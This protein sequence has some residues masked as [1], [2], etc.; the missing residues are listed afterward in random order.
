MNL[1]S[2]LLKQVA[3]LR[4]PLAVTIVSGWLGGVLLVLYARVLSRVVSLVFL[5]ASTPADGPSLPAL[6]AA[7]LALA[8]LR[9]GSVW[10]GRVTAQQTANG[11]KLRLRQ[12]L[13]R[14]LLKLGPAY[15]WGERTGELTN[16]LTEGIEA[17]DAYFGLYVPQLV[18]AVLVPLTIF[19]FVL[20]LDI[21]S[22]VIL[23]ATAP[24]I[25]LFMVLIGA[26]AGQMTQRQWTSLSR[27]SAH[28]LD[29]L[30]GLTTLKLLGRSRQQV[31]SVEAASEDFR[32]MTMGVLRIAFLSAL[33]L[34]MLAT[35]STAVVAVEIGLR[36]LYGRLVFEQAFFVLLLAP[37][38]YLPLRLLGTRFH[39]GAAGAASAR[40]IFEI[41][42][43]PV[44]SSPQV[45]ADHIHP[46]R[47]IRFS[48]VYYAY[49]GGARPALHG[50][51]LDLREGQRAALVGASGAG[52][53]TVVHLL[54]R[55]IA[56]DTGSI[57]VDGRSLQQIDPE[58]WRQWVAWVPQSPYL[59]HASV[60]E[61]IRLGRPEAPLAAVM[62]AAR[63]AHAEAFI[64]ELPD[65]YETQIGERGFRLSGG[66]AQRLALARAFLKDAP[67]LILDEATSSL[68]PVH[69]ALLQQSL[70]RLEEGRTVLT[71]AHRLSTV[72]HADRIY[73]LEGGRVVESGDH[74]SLLERQGVYFTMVTGGGYLSPGGEDGLR[75]AGDGRGLSG[76]CAQ[77]E[78]SG[79][80]FL[81]YGFASSDH[82]E[83][84]APAPARSG[85]SRA[86]DFGRLLRILAPYAGW[87]LLASLVGF[88]TIGSSIGLM[89]A[90]AY[91]IASAALHPSIAE[92]QV[93]IV[94]VRFFGIS[95]GGFRYL[96]RL[97]SHQATFRLLTRLRVWFYRSLEPLAPARLLQYRSGDLL[98]RVVADIGTLENFYLRVIAPP[99]VAVMVAVLAAVFLSSYHPSL[100]LVVLMGLLAAGVLMPVL[101]LR[102]SRGIGRR[103]IE[104]RARLSALIV[105]GV[106]GVAE[107][108]AFNMVE[109]HMRLVTRLDAGLQRLHLRLATVAGLQEGLFGLLVNLTTLGALIVGIP[110]VGSGAISGVSLAVLVLVTIATF[111]A[112]APLPAAWQHLE[113]NL[114]AARRLF[115][116]LDAAPAVTDPAQPLPLPQ[117]YAPS[118]TC[119]HGSPRKHEDRLRVEDLS[120]RYTPEAPLALN[121]VSLTLAPGRRVVLVGPSGSGKTTLVNLLLR[122]W[123]YDAGHIWLGTGS[124]QGG[125]LRDYRAEDVRR[126]LGVVGQAVHLFNATVRENLLLARPDAAEDDLVR[127]TQ[128]A[129]IYDFIVSLPQGLDTWIGEQG[130]LLSAGQRQ[131]LAVA[132][133]LLR[134]TPVLIFDEPTANLDPLVAAALMRD[135]L[136]MTASR[137]SLFITHRLVGLE[138]MDEILVLQRGR[139]VERGRHDELMQARG[140]YHRMWQ[141]HRVC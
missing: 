98:T 127:V 67:L 92:L 63:L 107:Q 86:R 95:R 87:M 49:E 58:Q 93:A 66:Q 17:L 3:G 42:E 80:T 140:L 55:F 7:L 117:T 60:A 41:L 135:V 23:L 20:P 38:F 25:P 84:A 139:I 39:D 115:E 18:T 102:L 121:G 116:I 40:R 131:R 14:H 2:R 141:L 122:F 76:S 103:T 53:S 109:R 48:E 136:Q 45:R 78:E 132:R 81:T 15:S 62:E 133:V 52:K 27:M 108:L 70:A 73:V 13:S 79:A 1:D 113:T 83:G 30:Q 8:L 68:D 47:H 74:T 43:T 100:A 130:V 61:N 56:P 137:S 57:E 101:T 22:A 11:V 64:S 10:V 65:G 118:V 72:R 54:L 44:L 19:A 12:Q 90:A 123:D 5:P 50:V 99:L 75:G 69:E 85:E 16:T 119:P 51:S 26:K 111:E 32:R 128:Q 82:G 114:A 31:R 97:L 6:L 126:L 106:Q 35:I 120:F 104:T 138:D 129:N 96:E 28:F 24:L 110:M 9:A 34:E 71:I 77:K 46:P 36:L 21:L 124:D 37:E 4:R 134:D 88:L 29:V 94:G 91:I 112:A 125:E 59:F 105:D 89:G 33:A